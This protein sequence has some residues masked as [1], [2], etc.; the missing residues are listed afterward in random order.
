VAS[1][2]GMDRNPTSG[3]LEDRASPAIEEQ[4]L[5]DALNELA[6]PE[7]GYGTMI[8]GAALVMLLSG[9]CVM[10]AINPNAVQPVVS[11]TLAGLII[12]LGVTVGELFW[13]RGVRRRMLALATAVNALQQA[14]STAEA[15]SRAKSR[16]LAATSHEIRTPMN[17][18]LGMISLLLDTE[19]N[20]E[21][22]NYAKTAE[23]SGRT[24]ISIIDELLDQSKAEQDHPDIRNVA[25]D[26]LALVESV[27][28]LLAPRA[29]AKAI[30]ISCHVA[31]EVPQSVLGD[32]QRLRQILF[33][34][35]GNAIKFT[36]KG[37]VSLSVSR[38]G[39]EQL[40]ITVADT[41]IGMTP[42]ETERIFDEFVQANADTK[43]LFGGTGLGLAISKRLAEALGGSIR[44]ESKAGIGTCFTVI[45]PLQ[46]VEPLQEQPQVL[47]GR[48][49]FLAI[50]D[51]PI[52]SHLALTLTELGGEVEKVSGDI[53]VATV[54][55]T[56]NPATSTALIA[57][58]AHAEAL[59]SWARQ[60]SDGNGPSQVF[61][62]MQAEERKEFKDLLKH[63][64]AG[65]LLKPFRRGTLIRQ[66]TAHDDNMLDAA[67]AGL[68][69]L[70]KIQARERNGL[71]VLLAEDNPVNALLARTM[72]EKAGCRVTHAAN[73]RHALS[74]L[75]GGLAPNLVIMDVEMPELDG[76]EATQVIR[77][78]EKR[79]ISQLPILAL[80]A[81]SR[82]EDYEEC[83]AAGMD[84]HL[85]KPFDR[86]DL[87]EAIE[88]LLSRRPAA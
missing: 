30:G 83:L 58:T 18:V 29:H 60:P 33:N 52:A 2:T 55:A 77:R 54:L 46:P 71:H 76:L 42:D 88:K 43:R 59:R 53:G 70:Q 82:R 3:R 66:L 16:F 44:A 78:S 8:A 1:N 61:V 49:Y 5:S 73:G 15:S 13:R 86:Q 22:R 27:T 39:S 63:P 68:R 40:A 56:C 81:N 72:L 37:G 4:V 25:F 80:T 23:S 32:P 24:L 19:L 65:Y 57:D 21:Q 36:D 34:L 35:C 6:R 41:G 67:V 62:I 84:G 38:H 87:D 11:L 26:I 20:E 64:F 28:E 85:S 69:G 79:S 14:R 48:R 50:D 75:D 31:C 45:L 7:L 74:L 9:A 10:L 12:S 17:G 51:G 47:A